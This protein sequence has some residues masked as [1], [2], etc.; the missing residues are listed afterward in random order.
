MFQFDDTQEVGFTKYQ[1]ME[2]QGKPM[3]IFTNNDSIHVSAVSKEAIGLVSIM[4]NL[5]FKESSIVT[6]HRLD[7]SVDIVAWD[8]SINH[9]AYILGDSPTIIHTS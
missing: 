4:P 8:E 1:E 7:R 9:L 3:Q 2:I 6:R 5:I